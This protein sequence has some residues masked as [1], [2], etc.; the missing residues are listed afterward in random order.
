MAE[1]PKAA[2]DYIENIGDTSERTSAEQ[3]IDQLGEQGGIFVKA[4]ALTR[5]PMIVTDPTL[6]GNPIVFANPAFEELSGYSLDELTGQDP[7]FLNGPDTSPADI[8]RYQ[9][10][11]EQGRQIHLELLQYR[12]DSTPFRAMLFASALDDGQ[13]KVTNHFLSYLDVTRRYEAER[14]LRVQAAQLEARVQQRTQ[15]LED[16]NARLLKIDAQRQMLLAEVNHRAKNS[17]AIAAALLA[18]QGR[19][20]Q[21]EAVRGLFEEAH[22]RLIAMSR[23]HDLLSR[24]EHLQRVDLAVYMADI[25]EALRPITLDDAR[26]SLDARIDSGI[27]VDADTGIPLGIIATELITN[28][29]KYA[30]PEGR[31]G[32]IVAKGSATA[33]TVEL[34]IQDD[35]VGMKEIRE[36]SLGI[37][38]VRSLVGQIGGRMEMSGEAGLRVR[39]TFPQSQAPLAAGPL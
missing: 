7:H 26:I 9:E 30:F 17:L 3:Y 12:K 33:G 6:P 4:V 5:M 35:G 8:R 38:L 15:D 28:A 19:R 23:V 14:A 20:Q 31:A 32:S 10:A 24:S 21:D 36:G 11:M 25:C 18:I 16:A 13:G 22:D 34:V 29:I 1:P 27:L 39:I 37:G 2:N